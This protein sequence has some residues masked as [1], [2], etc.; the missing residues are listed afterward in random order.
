MSDGLKTLK[1]MHTTWSKMHSDSASFD[2]LTEVSRKY[3]S[4]SVE[5]RRAYVTWLN[6]RRTP[7]RL[8]NVGTA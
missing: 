4:L 2:L 6:S 1:D 8:G 7:I 3:Y 5:D